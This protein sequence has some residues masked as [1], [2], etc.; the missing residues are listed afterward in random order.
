MRGTERVNLDTATKEHTA[1]DED[2]EGTRRRTRHKALRQRG[3]MGCTALCHV[4]SSVLYVLSMLGPGLSAGLTVLCAVLTKMPFF[5]TTAPKGPPCWRVTPAI[6]ELAA[7][8]INAASAL[9]T[10]ISFAASA[11]VIKER[12]LQ[13]A[14]RISKGALLSF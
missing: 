6:A 9:A 8:P 13:V 2:D 12:S 4:P 3:A 7:A 14:H 5:T 10:S 11:I 1:P